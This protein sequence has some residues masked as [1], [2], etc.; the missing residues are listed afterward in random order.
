M[1]P[2]RLS[3][4]LVALTLSLAGTG[5]GAQATR[6]VTD[7]LKLEA[8]SGPGTSNRILKML[9]SGT[10]VR[11]VDERDGWSRIEL[12]GAEEAWILSRYLTEE[13]PARNRLDAALAELERMR[14]EIGSGNTQLNALQAEVEALRE[15]RDSFASKAETI[16][17]ELAELKETAS[18]AV[19]LRERNTRLQ[20][21]SV[22]M[23][24]KLDALREDYLTL[25]DA[26]GRDWFLA[27]AGVLLGGMILGLVIPRIRWRRRRSWS[28]L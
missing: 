7:Q 18:G 17:R 21:D 3:T 26:R 1:R 20:E 12:P 2:S 23:K 5:A 19:A 22:A 8:R 11:V 24:Q 27:G 13:E 6:Y 10:R 28:E 9:E 4:A 16:A 14:S 15:D 25:R